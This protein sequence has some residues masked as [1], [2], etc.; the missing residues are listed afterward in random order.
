MKNQAY[1]NEA[2]ESQRKEGEGVSSRAVLSR[3]GRKILTQYVKRGGEG[4][5]YEATYKIKHVI[6]SGFE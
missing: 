6:T 5:H 1:E 4:K 2:E 3:E